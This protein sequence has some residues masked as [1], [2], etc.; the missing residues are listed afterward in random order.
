MIENCEGCGIKSF[1][2]KI[3]LRLSNKWD[4]KSLQVEN[5]KQRFLFC[6]ESGCVWVTSV[7][8]S[9]K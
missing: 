2:K 4:M 3:M 7:L 5:I 6:F 9:L 8:S 1:T